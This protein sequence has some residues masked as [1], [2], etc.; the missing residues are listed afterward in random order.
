MSILGKN[1][2]NI[3]DLDYLVGEFYTVRMSMI[4]IV[5]QWSPYDCHSE[6]ITQ[7]LIVHHFACHIESH[8][9]MALVSPA[10]ELLY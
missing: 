1:G 6:A 7:L 5:G 4:L 2:K 8:V 10:L 9:I 3:D